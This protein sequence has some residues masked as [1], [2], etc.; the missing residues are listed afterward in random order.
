MTGLGGEVKTDVFRKLAGISDDLQNQQT[1]G[2]STSRQT[3]LW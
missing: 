1:P 3:E 2:F